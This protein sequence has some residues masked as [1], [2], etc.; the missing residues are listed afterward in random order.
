[1]RK[2][3]GEV[4]MASYSENLSRQLHGSMERY[5]LDA[6]KTAALIAWGSTVTESPSLSSVQGQAIANNGLEDLLRIT[7][8]EVVLDLAVA[9][10]LQAMSGVRYAVVLRKPGAGARVAIYM[11]KPQPPDLAI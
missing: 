8:S 9:V 3:I 1:M 10:M 11:G 2:R 5:D 4:S 7:A 6:P